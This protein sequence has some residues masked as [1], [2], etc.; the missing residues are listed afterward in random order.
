MPFYEGLDKFIDF[1]YL[2]ELVRKKNPDFEYNIVQ[3]DS[4]TYTTYL[5]TKIMAGDKDFDIFHCE[6]GNFAIYAQSGA[7]ADLPEYEEIVN[8]INSMFEGFGNLCMHKICQ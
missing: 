6:N 7:C 3:I 8:N 4:T 1:E 5:N 2:I